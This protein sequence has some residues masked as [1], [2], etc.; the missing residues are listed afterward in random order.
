MVGDVEV[1]AGVLL[2][3]EDPPFGGPVAGVAAGLA[4]LGEATAG[5]RPPW[6]LLLASDLP[7]AEGAVRRLFEVDPG[8]HDGTVLLAADG[9]PQWL[10]GCYRLAALTAQLARPDCPR[11]LFGLLEPLNLLA[12]PTSADVTA[13]VDTVTDAARWSVTPPQGAS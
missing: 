7:H 10:I 9:R 1:P 6:V 8:D 11:S 5:A 13:D 3:R 2:T 12:V 4:S